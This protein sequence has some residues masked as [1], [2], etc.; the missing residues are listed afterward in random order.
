[1]DAT[2]IHATPASVNDFWK[3]ELAEIR[4]A[5]SKN[6]GRTNGEHD[7]ATIGG[8]QGKDVRDSINQGHDYGD[9]L[10]L[11]LAGELV[12][13]PGNGHAAAKPLPSPP[14]PSPSPEEE[15]IIRDAGERCLFPHDTGEPITNEALPGEP[16]YDQATAEFEAKMQAA[17][18][19][20]SDKEPTPPP[21]RLKTIIARLTNRFSGFPRMVGSDLFTIH[22]DKVEF[23]HKPPALFA[24]FARFGPVEW[25]NGPGFVP[26]SQLFEAWRQLTQTHESVQVI[27]HEPPLPGHYYL[28]A[29]PEPGDGRWLER[30][31]DFFCPET[32][33]DRMLMKAAMATPMWGGPPGKRPLFTVLSLLGRGKGK[34]TFCQKIGELYGGIIDINADEDPVKIKGRF[35]TPDAVAIRVWMI[36]N[37]KTT[38]FS[39]GAL[40]SLVTAEEISGWR[41][42]HGNSNRKNYFTPFVTCNGAS[43]SRDFA[44]RTV[45]I[46]LGEPTYSVEWERNLAEFLQSYRDEILG[47]II[48]FLRSTPR[49]IAN[50]TRWALW[51]GEVLARVESPDECVKL[52]KQR[53]EALDVEIEEGEII[54]DFFCGRLKALGYDPDQSDIFLPNQTATRWYNEALGE[55]RSVTAVSRAL[56]QAK[57]ESQISRISPCRF[58]TEG[59]RG[60][61]WV[62]EHCDSMAD[63]Y[64]DILYRIE[65][66]RED[67]NRKSEQTKS[68]GRILAE[69]SVHSTY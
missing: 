7:I 56:R 68:E 32:P 62:G 41:P 58:G 21:A 65:K 6:G 22:N 15:K 49:P 45:E 28:H 47:D 52:I 36:D 50:A 11:A 51:E 17:S 23:H 4:A 43:F 60:F 14:P 19:D 5:E 16:E 10:A 44:Q 13:P 66:K 34:T 54:E 25:R 3:S 1:M 29:A 42:F 57:E 69:T 9:L 63:T 24:W 61:R 64:H 59:G 48:G 18:R 67:E 55:K 27:P 2:A 38:R 30:F 46:R 53:R 12:L 26:Q 37:L 20:T 35:L 39:S 33:I 8:G 40:E 31:L